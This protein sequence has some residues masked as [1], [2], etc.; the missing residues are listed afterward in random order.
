M[1]RPFDRA[2][3]VVVVDACTMSAGS[4][5]EEDDGLATIDPIPYQQT[6]TT[7]TDDNDTSEVDNGDEDEL[8]GNGRANEEEEGGEAE[9]DEDDEEEEGDMD[10]D[11]D[12]DEEDEEPK[13]KY[14]KVTSS[15]ASV[16]RNGDATSSS[17]VAGDKMVRSVSTP[18]TGH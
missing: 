2:V 17:L 12:E 5:K 13:L 6:T 18:I 10:E 15:L 7:D 1:S 16:Y 4:G 9:N 11:D 8:A 3:S 14:T